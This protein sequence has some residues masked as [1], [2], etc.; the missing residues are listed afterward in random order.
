MKRYDSDKVY[1]IAEAGV[2]HNGQRD[3]A[4]SLIDAAAEAGTDA[5]KFQTFDAQ[6]L[7]LK[8]APK[9]AYQNHQTDAAESQLAML[10]KLELPREWHLELQAY[11]RDKGIDFLSTAFDMDSLAFLVELDI[12]VFKVP[13]GE[14]TNGPLLWQFA[15]TRKP[16]ILS[17]GMATLSE[18]EQ[19][20][21]IV[22]HALY[23]DAEPT[24]MDEIWRY[25]S[26]PEYR[27]NLKGH[28]TL[29]H[30]TSLYPTPLNEVNLRG[31]DTLASA[32]GLDVG[33]SDHTEGILVPLAAV[34]RGA[35][36]IEKHFTIDRTLRGP[37]HM[38][39]LEPD[40]LKQMVNDI[41][42]LQA[43]FGD[44]NKSP[45]LSEW[46]TRQATRQQVVAAREIPAGCVLLRRDLTTAR[47]GRGL[48][49]TALWGLVGQLASRSFTAGEIIEL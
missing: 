34:A 10:K 20:L 44:G 21:A 33:Y 31:M 22:V 32:F 4:F 42:A 43:A 16:L 13:S 30:C 38:A 3:L 26:N 8:S 37:D 48:P 23:A 9:A 40:K 41:R 28:V 45:Q 1:I 39:S 24:S 29:L 36:V 6:K 27:S 5:V 46:D 49:P 14:L 19:G 18:V 15:R 17:T 12:P 7:A 47:S 2:N 35:K 11:S 25:W